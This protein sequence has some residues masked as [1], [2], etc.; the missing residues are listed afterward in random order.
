MNVSP[1][2]VYTLIRDGELIAASFGGK[3][4]IRGENIEWWIEQHK[5]RTETE[6]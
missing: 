4:R 1:R 5:K 2:E 6:G 3:Y